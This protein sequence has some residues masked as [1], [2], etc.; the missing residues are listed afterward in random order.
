MNLPDEGF[1]AA[2]I[3]AGWVL[4]VVMLLWSL[5]TAPWHKIK[6]DSEAQNVFLGATVLLFFAWQ[7]GA[8]IGEGLSF[9]VLLVTTLTLMFG[10]QFAFF[11]ASIALIGVTAMGDSGAMMFGMNAFLMAVLPIM[12]VWWMA[13]FA[14]RYLDRHF[15]VFVLFNGFFAAA[16]STSFALFAAAGVMW[17]G[18]LHPAEKL[19]QSFVPYIPMMVI[20]EAFA[21]GVLVLALVILRP[22]WVSCFDDDEYLKGK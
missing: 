9:H 1:S 7:G 21:N 6:G 20:P 17:L 12:I 2:W 3:I 11:S 14:Y 19:V 16:V 5:K 13:V 8:S 4:F 10:P 18:E 15:F 22:N